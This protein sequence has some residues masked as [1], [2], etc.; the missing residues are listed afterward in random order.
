MS[1]LLPFISLT[2][3]ITSLA[4]GTEYT[5]DEI[6]NALEKKSLNLDPAHFQN[7]AKAAMA[8]LCSA[9]FD[10]KINFFGNMHVESMQEHIFH[11]I[12]EIPPPLFTK[13][14]IYMPFD[15]ILWHIDEENRSIDYGEYFSA[16]TH[17][18]YIKNVT[19]QRSDFVQFKK[20]W[21]AP[22]VQKFTDSE[23][24]KWIL[25]CIETIGD[26]AYRLFKLHPQYD[27]TDQRAF[28]E[29]WR[30]IRGAKVGRPKK[31]T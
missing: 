3:A 13:Y 2:G 6:K 29:Q 16:L 19:L 20:S 25:G 14:R 28:R 30:K 10:K 9:G 26:K 15:D 1:K 31:Q 24:E 8:E 22:K 21:R 23:R 12:E 7:L 5:G 11:S 18:S 17:G 27:G 4:I